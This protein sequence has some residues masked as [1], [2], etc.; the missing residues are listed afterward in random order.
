MYV[1]IH[2]RYGYPF[3]VGMGQ[4]NR[5][6][7]M[8]QGRN[9]HHLAV[10]KKSLQEGSFSCEVIYEGN[11]NQCGEVERKLIKLWGRKG[12]DRGGI[13]TNYVEGGTGGN[14]Y[15]IHNYEDRIETQRRNTNQLWKSQEYRRNHR[16]GM[17]SPQLSQAQ[18][19][20]FSTQE[21]R[22]KHSLV[23]QKSHLP[24][25]TRKLLYGNKNKGRKW[26][27]NPE[28]GEE[29]LT[30]NTPPEG[31]VSGRYKLKYK[32]VG[33]RPKGIST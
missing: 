5:M 31:W 21:N 30:H 23:T 33:G 25:D 14:T 10:W 29:I 11:R 26:Y 19:Q 32:G 7:N 12:I 1:Y 6:T 20:R 18:K 17:K 15:T 28:T 2:R 9:R 3:Y 16:E 4:G 13:L 22:D 24:E 8:K 27:H